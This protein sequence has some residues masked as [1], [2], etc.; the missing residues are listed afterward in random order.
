[1]EEEN[2]GDGERPGWAVRPDF[3]DERVLAQVGTRIPFEVRYP[4]P[5]DA[6]G[7]EE[8]VALTEEIHDP[9]VGNVFE[10]VL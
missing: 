2:L 6:V 4:D 3:V 8:P 9:Q 5:A 7:L 1:M 10:K